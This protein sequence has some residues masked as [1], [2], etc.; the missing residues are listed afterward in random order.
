MRASVGNVEADEAKC[1]T[2][3]CESVE[4]KEGGETIYDRG[5]QQAPNLGEHMDAR[6]ASPFCVRFIIAIP[7]EFMQ[8]VIHFARAWHKCAIQGQGSV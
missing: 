7:V 2:F 6:F 3:C 4:G 1:V 5:L 8:F